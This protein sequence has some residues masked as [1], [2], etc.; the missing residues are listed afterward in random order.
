[1]AVTAQQIF[2]FLV[3]NPNISDADLAAVMDTFGVSPQ[4]VA[5]ATGTSEAE[6]QQRYEAV[7]ALLLLLLLL[8]FITLFTKHLFTSPFM[9][10][11]FINLL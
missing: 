7:T 10:H 6:A 3:A 1:M 11:P 5:Q 4:Q 2:D 8:Q 9:K